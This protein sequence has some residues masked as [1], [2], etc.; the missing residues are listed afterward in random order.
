MN[1]NVLEYELILII[2]LFNI[3]TLFLMPTLIFSYIDLTLPSKYFIVADFDFD[4]Q[5]R[6]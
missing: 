5:V 4:L 1:S 2:E 3:L 6:L